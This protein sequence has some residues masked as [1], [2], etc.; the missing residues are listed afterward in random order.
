MRCAPDDVAR[1]GR[2]QVVA[3][4][5]RPARTDA[6]TIVTQSYGTRRSVLKI[7]INSSTSKVGVVRTVVILN[8]WR[9]PLHPSGRRKLGLGAKDMD[10][11]DLN[12]HS[13]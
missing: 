10:R 11:I 2:A 4:V 13:Q 5:F 8:P 3:S 6:S 9:R 7:E 1:L 12:G